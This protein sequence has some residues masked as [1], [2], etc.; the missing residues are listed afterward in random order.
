MLRPHRKIKQRAMHSLL[1]AR[2]VSLIKLPKKS[3]SSEAE[4]EAQHQL[5][6]KQAEESQR[7]ESWRA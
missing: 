3:P 4:L 7:Q 6:L 5:A 2:R 1:K